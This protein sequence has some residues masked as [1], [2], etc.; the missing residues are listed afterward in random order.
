M[1]KIVVIGSMNMDISYRVAHIPAPG[2]TIMASAV[3]KSP[4]GKGANQAVA[5]AKLGADVSMIGCVGSDGDGDMLC[6]SL[7]EAG[8][9]LAM[10]ER[11]ADAPTGTAFINVADDGENNI[12]VHPGANARV[13]EAL[14]ERAEELIDGAQIL[15][16]Q[17]EIPHE[18]VWK[19]LKRGRELGVY[20]VLNPSPI[21]E[22]PDDVLDGIDLL[23]PNE[24]E[25]SALLGHPVDPDSG[26]VQRFAEKKGVRCI[27]MTKGA[28]GC[29]LVTASGTQHIPCTPKKAVDTTGAGDTFLGALCAMLA[30]GGGM[31][32]A[33]GIA[34]R[35]SAYAVQRMGA[36]QSMPRWSDLQEP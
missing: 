34:Q 6:R 25:M 2:E 7:S 22:V 14:L 24:A 31:E 35:A 10:M 5:A 32:E 27:L 1:G 11:S 9:N 16:S 26:D 3:V 36:Q 4:G 21:A 12:V 13:D 8:V 15:I 33:I 28:E 29:Y 17:L 23:I 30:K 19:A 20:T 18:T